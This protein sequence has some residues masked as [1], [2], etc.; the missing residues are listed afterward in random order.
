M[1][2]GNSSAQ[3]FAFTA[4]CVRMRK[5]CQRNLPLATGD[6]EWADSVTEKPEAELLRLWKDR[7]LLSS[8]LY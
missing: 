3:H 8:P 6:L 1:I 5:F 4:K 7:A 2:M